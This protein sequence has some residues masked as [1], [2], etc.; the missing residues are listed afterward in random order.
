MNWNVGLIGLVKALHFFFEHSRVKRTGSWQ[1]TPAHSFCVLLS[2]AQCYTGWSRCVSDG[3]YNTQ[4]EIFELL[5]QESLKKQFSDWQIKRTSWSSTQPT[6][7]LE[8]VNS[9][10]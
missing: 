5:T 6:R 4:G 10:R 2:L 8:V 7:L 1:D 9:D 3:D